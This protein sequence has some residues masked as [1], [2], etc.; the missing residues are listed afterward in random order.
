MEKTQRSEVRSVSLYPDD[1]EKIER[2]AKR[3]SVSVSAA[4]RI[5]IEQWKRNQQ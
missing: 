5:I 3:Y 2:V 1:W 4:I